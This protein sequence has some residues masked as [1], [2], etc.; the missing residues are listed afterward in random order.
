M[1]Q[2]CDSQLDY[3]WRQYGQ[4]G[5]YRCPNVDS[6]AS[7]LNAALDVEIDS[8]RGFRSHA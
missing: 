2:P 8:D 5:S 6:S 7:R 1:C 3:D 4:L